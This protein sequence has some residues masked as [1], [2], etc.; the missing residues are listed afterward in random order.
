MKG[1]EEARKEGEMEDLIAVVKCIFL[2]ASFS[3]GM[4]SWTKLLSRFS[5]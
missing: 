4:I 5:L 1:R 2:V 3:A